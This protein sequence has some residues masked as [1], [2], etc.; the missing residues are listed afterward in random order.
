MPRLRRTGN[1]A[2]VLLLTVGAGRLGALPDGITG[3][4]GREADCGVCHSGGQTPAVKFEGPQEVVRETVADF[5]F[6]VASPSERQGVAGFDVASS[7]GELQA[8][9][10]SQWVGG[11]LTHTE[12]LPAQNGIAAWDFGW[13]APAEIGAYILWGAGLSANGN[14]NR[15]GDGVG[16]VSYTVF[17]LPDANCDGRVS[18]ADLVAT[19]RSAAGNPGACQ[20]GDADCDGTAATSDLGEFARLVFDPAAV[21][22]CSA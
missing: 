13:R 3:F 1:L 15:S 4:S 9:Q 17:V 22:N 10:G 11:E 21:K 8:G 18:A 7:G 19:A 14:G 5:R 6:L 12:P 2:V 20:R 16:T